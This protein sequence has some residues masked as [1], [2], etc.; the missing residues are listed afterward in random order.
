LQLEEA[1][2]A[3]GDEEAGGVLMPLEDAGSGRISA[4]PAVSRQISPS[5]VVGGRRKEV[6]REE[7]RPEAGAE[8]PV[9]RGRRWR[10]PSV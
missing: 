1:G 5:E 6:L 2:S 4:D 9:G 8:D 10:G 3:V 7:L